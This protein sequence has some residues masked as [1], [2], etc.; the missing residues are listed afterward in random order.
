MTDITFSSANHLFNQKKYS[1][2]FDQFRCLANK[3]EN[4]A[5]CSFMAGKCL[6]LCGKDS[7]VFSYYQKALEF[8]DSNAFINREIERYILDNKLIEP[9]K[10]TLWHYFPNTTNIG[11]SGST[12]GIRSLFHS[13]TDDF[14]FCTLSC[15]KDTID[16]LKSFKKQAAGIIIGGG[17]LFFKQ[18]LASG[19]YFPLSL[20]EINSLTMPKITY[21]IGFN[22][23]YTDSPQWNLDQ[24]FITGIAKFH[25]GFSLKSVRDYWSKNILEKAGVSDLYAV[26]CPSAF[27]KPLPWYTMLIDKSKEIVGLSITDRA[28]QKDH[29]V[30]LFSVFFKFAQW[31]LQ[32]GYSPLFILQDTADDLA[33][34]KIITENNYNC[35]LPNTSREAISIYNQ[36]TY[37][38]GMRGHSLILAFG[39]QVPILGISYNKKV[40]AF[41][42]MLDLQKYCLNQNDLTDCTILIKNFKRLIANKDEVIAVLKNKR[43]VFYRSNI[44]YCKKAISLISKS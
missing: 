37:V 24:N 43:E 7:D 2:A 38:I 17:G 6:S 30:K 33:L 25:Q 1:E 9:N 20:S 22:K 29:K 15:R 42:E 4:P 13:L 28:L 5:F 18:P 8:D 23:E 35:I 44:E 26:P 27:L 32:N 34:A 19:W 41:M 11:D 16:V 10:H 21:A 40:D 31:L 12:A 39:Q 36:C 14:F 3:K